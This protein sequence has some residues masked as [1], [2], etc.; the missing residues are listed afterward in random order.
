[1]SGMKNVK[2]SEYQIKSSSTDTDQISEVGSQVRYGILPLG[3]EMGSLSFSFQGQKV[4]I[5]CILSLIVLFITISKL[6]LVD[7]KYAR[8]ILNVWGQIISFVWCLSSTHKRI[9]CL[10]YLAYICVICLYIVLYFRIIFYYFPLNMMKSCKS[11]WA[12]HY[13]VYYVN[14]LHA[15]LHISVPSLATHFSCEFI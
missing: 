6:N 8:R 4:Q 9:V 14:K 1:M 7:R 12:G 11:V 5:K 10:N 15:F 2:F 13:W 3:L